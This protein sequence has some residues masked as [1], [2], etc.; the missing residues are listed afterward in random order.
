MRDNNGVP[1]ELEKAK[2]AA[3]TSDSN[4][5][6]TTTDISGSAGPGATNSQIPTNS[7]DISPEG[8]LNVIK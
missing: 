1:A 3:A 5:D 2:Q 4:K 7:D 8:L 6:A